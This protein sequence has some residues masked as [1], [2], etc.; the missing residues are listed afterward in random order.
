MLHNCFPF[1]PIII[2]LH[3]KNPL[4]GRMCPMDVGRFMSWIF[5]HRLSMNWGCAILMSGSKGQG[6]NALI[7]ENGF[8][9]ITAFPLHL[10]SANFSHTFPMSQGY[11]L[12]TLWVKKNLGSLNLLPQGVFVSLGQPLM[13]TICQTVQIWL[14]TYSF[15]LQLR[16]ITLGCLSY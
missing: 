7:I 12:M 8:W 10:R 14:S 13:T 16:S 5:T 4:E 1:K 15:H 6:H 3:T 9:R 2:K 11:A